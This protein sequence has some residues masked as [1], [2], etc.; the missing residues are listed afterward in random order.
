ML[1]CLDPRAL[2]P[3]CTRTF[4]SPEDEHE[5]DNGDDGDDDEPGV[6]ETCAPCQRRVRNAT[7]VPRGSRTASRFVGPHSLVICAAPGWPARP[8]APSFRWFDLSEPGSPL[9]P[10]APNE[11]GP[12]HLPDHLPRD[13]K[14]AS[15]VISLRWHV[16]ALSTRPAW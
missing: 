6:H 5:Y 8:G 16:P 10:F 7:A 11:N 14:L 15:S 2:E 4:R 1:A 3:A 12:P 9:V 13:P